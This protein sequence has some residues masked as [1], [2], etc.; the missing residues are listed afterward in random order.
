MRTMMDTPL[1]D[2][3]DAF[4][5]VMPTGFFVQFLEEIVFIDILFTLYDIR[6]GFK[7]F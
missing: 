6:K 4:F 3:F 5:T 2:I 7:Y 1:R